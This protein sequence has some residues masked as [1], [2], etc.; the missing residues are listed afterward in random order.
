MNTHKIISVF[1]IACCCF[2]LS[3]CWDRREL[4]D[5]ALVSGI[6]ID[7]GKNNKY[8]MTA[9]EIIAS[10]LNPKTGGKASPSFVFSLEGDTIAE[11]VRKLNIGFSR[12]MEYSH[13]KTLVIHE[14]IAREGLLEFLD[15]MR[16]NREI[17]NDFNIVVAHEVPAADI[18]K[19]SNPLQKVPSFK[20]WIQ[21]H[22]MVRD[23][24]G[25]P[26]V[27]LGDIITAL[28]I[29]GREPIMASVTIKGEP[30]KGNDM[31]NAKKIQPDAMVVLDGLA[32]FKGMK[33]QG[34]M[35]IKDTNNY[36]WI[37]D[38]IRA[39]TITVHCNKNNAFTVRINNVN[40]DVKVEYKEGKPE[41]V[42]NIKGEGHLAA[43]QCPDDIG[44]IKTI[45]KYENMAANKIKREV[46]KTI[47]TTQLKFGSDI[48]G[49]GEK[50]YRQHPKQFEKVVDYWN[51]E[52]KKAKVN[53]H[54]NIIIH[55]PELKTNTF[56]HQLQNDQG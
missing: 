29:K 19:V 52:F 41:V 31:D 46:E 33:M 25:D 21:L 47:E 16:R 8:K 37:Q 51:N 45:K 18:L 35:D 50:L 7:K 24:G 49:F 5:I 48:F 56:L 3:G 22:T 44:D 30:K 42:I 9:E 6:A 14:D 4:N 13:M 43:T 40:S 2:L 11:L 27:K 38:K 26:D 15:F 54:V 32:V 36:L 17:R 12:K 23:W 34:F 53:V 1:L 28:L 20:M 10:E 39:T 55:R